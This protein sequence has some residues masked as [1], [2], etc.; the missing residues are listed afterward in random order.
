MGVYS[1]LVKSLSSKDLNKINEIRERVCVAIDIDSSS[2]SEKEAWKT[3]LALDAE[4][5]NV[6][7]QQDKQILE[8]LIE[9]WLAAAGSLKKLDFVSALLASIPND[10]LQTLNHDFPIQIEASDGSLVPISYADG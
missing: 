9:P 3:I 1:S 5:R 6:A 2:E 4:I 10:Q 7:T 8:T